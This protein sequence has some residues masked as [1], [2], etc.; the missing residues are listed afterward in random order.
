MA[1]SVGV[2]DVGVGGTAMA[3]RPTEV[4]GLDAIPLLSLVSGFSFEFVVIGLVVDEVRGV[5]G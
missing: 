4:G 3:E 2:G 5:F 1:E